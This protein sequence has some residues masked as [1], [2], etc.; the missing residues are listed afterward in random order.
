MRPDGVVALPV[1]LPDGERSAVAT[2]PPGEGVAPAGA[3]AAGAGAEGD[4]TAATWIR[5]RFK[6]FS[7]VQSF[8]TCFG[9]S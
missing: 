9:V 3:D 7:S 4:A 2:R 6:D 8:R 5:L 1:K